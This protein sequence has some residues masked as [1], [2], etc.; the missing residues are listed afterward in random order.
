MGVGRRWKN[1]NEAA[2]EA[3]PDSVHTTRAG[4]WI[5]RPSNGSVNDSANGAAIASLTLPEARHTLR[6][7]LSRDLL[8][9]QT[10]RVRVLLATR[11][12]DVAQLDSWVERDAERRELLVEVEDLKRRRNE[13]SKKIGL[14]KREGGDADAQI[15]EVGKIKA[16][17]EEIEGRL[18]DLE[19]TLD[20]DALGIP[21]L[22][23]ESVPEGADESAN[24]EERRVGTPREFDFEPKAHW[25]LSLIHI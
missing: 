11:G 10:A 14:I 18:G 8:R 5:R 17:I 16:R 3:I 4:G 21:N 2:S 7:M 20:L 1:G 19:A 25:D 6:A 22:P 9:H 24:R 15:A 12:F 23:H 13:E